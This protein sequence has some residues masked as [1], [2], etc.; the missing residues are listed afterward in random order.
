M[1]GFE[2]N[3]NKRLKSYNDMRGALLTDHLLTGSTYLGVTPRCWK[4]GEQ[5]VLRVP[6]WQQV[7]HPFDASD[8][9]KDAENIARAEAVDKEVAKYRYRPGR[10]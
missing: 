5:V 1:C 10:V 6:R 4:T 9:I 7:D 8:F 3:L 2:S